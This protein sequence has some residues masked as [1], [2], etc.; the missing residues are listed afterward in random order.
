VEPRIF[1]YCLSLSRIAEEERDVAKAE[2]DVAKAER[3]VAKAALQLFLLSNHRPSSSDAAATKD[4]HVREGQLQ[5]N[6]AQA[7]W[8]LSKSELSFA[9]ARKA[10]GVELEQKRKA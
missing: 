8:N 10:L 7:E 6:A 2:R 9:Q 3:N 5:L 1:T 4:F